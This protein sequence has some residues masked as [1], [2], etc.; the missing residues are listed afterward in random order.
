MRLASN[1][2]LTRRLVPEAFGAMALVNSLIVGLQMFSDM[3]TGPAIQK[4]KHGDDPNFLDPVWT[5]QVM[6]GVVLTAVSVVIA[7]PIAW[8]YKDPIFAHI[9]PV[10]ALS[11]LVAGFT[12]TTVD[13]ATRHLQVG[14]L[15]QLELLSQLL[16]VLLTIALALWFRSVWAL[17][18]GMVIAGLINVAVMRIGLGGRSNHFCWDA[19]ALGELHE[20][21]RWIFL[22]TIFGFLIFNGDRLVLARYLTLENLGIYNIAYLY[23]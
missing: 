5:V 7:W 20:F 2:V 14:R 10:A 9:F 18:W 3:G 22:S 19:V 15:T 1:L 23:C 21:G 12:P 6:R 8:F 13:T 16:G 17:C 11:L 4:S